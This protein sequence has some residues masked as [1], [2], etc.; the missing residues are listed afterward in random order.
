VISRAPQGKGVV[1]ALWI[2]SATALAG[3]PDYDAFSETDG[4]IATKQ[5]EVAAW[6]MLHDPAQVEAVYADALKGN[7]RAV[8]IVQQIEA[9]L[10]A[11]GVEVAERTSRPGCLVP[12]Y[13]E[14]S[15]TCRP[16]WSFLD[17]LSQD[18]PGGI[19]LREVIFSAYAARAQK[20][21]LENQVVLT[22]ANGLLSVGLARSLLLRV[23]A[24]TKPVA[25]PVLAGAERVKKGITSPPRKITSGSQVTEDVIRQAIKDAPL[26]SQQ[27]RGVSLPR[28]QEYVDKIL[29]GEAA[30]AI[31]VDGNIIV[32]GHHRYI[33][34]RVLGQEPP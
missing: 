33:A 29:A 31:K 24:G 14:L 5:Q 6:E 2:M 30:P 7:V 17:F 19:R 26:K 3:A 18:R 16:D 10:A 32:D 34:G 28:V 23:E 9:T 4:H 25:T 8:R 22:A 12:A 21:G 1:L 27:S 15:G 11:S 13:Q 20:R